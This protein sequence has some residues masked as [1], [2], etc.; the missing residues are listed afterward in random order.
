MRATETP[1][2]AAQRR[3][4]VNVPVFEPVLI[5]TLRDPSFVCPST[6]SFPP[7]LVVT[8]QRGCTD[9]PMVAQDTRALSPRL[10]T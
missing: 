4:N 9:I 7:E 8:L 3:V 2:R 10:T 6:I 5:E 1:E